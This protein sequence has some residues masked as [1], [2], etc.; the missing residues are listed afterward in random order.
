MSR[1]SFCDNSVGRKQGVFCS[2]PCKNLFHYNCA[3]IP[4][5][6][7]IYLNSVSGLQWKCYD[8]RNSDSKCE[9]KKFLELLDKRCSEILNEFS[10]KFDTLKEEVRAVSLTKSVGDPSSLTRPVDFPVKPSYAQISRT[11]QKIVVKPKD[12]KQVNSRTK[13][14]LMHAVNPVNSDILIENVK[15]TRDGGVVLECSEPVALN[16]LKAI[17]DKELSDKYDIH[18]LKSSHPHIRIVGMSEC[19]DEDTLKNCLFKQNPNIF[20][21]NS[22]VKF[23]RSWPTKKHNDVFQS[24]LQLDMETYKLACSRGYVLIGFDRCSVYEVFDL[25]RCYNCNGFNHSKKFCKN[26]TRCPICSGEHELKNCPDNSVKQ[27]INC[28]NLKHSSKLDINIDHT[29]WDFNNCF[30]YKK[31]LEKCKSEML[32]ALS[33]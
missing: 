20:S 6:L 9:T 27:C 11:M 23:V 21:V 22:V 18:L 30:A 17:A 3:N 16:K 7:V 12:T 14:D 4:S 33:T 10:A 25:T 32:G 15:H 28:I 26:K 5:E 2:G 19:Y 29:A 31:A 13:Y 1:C 8:C 24:L